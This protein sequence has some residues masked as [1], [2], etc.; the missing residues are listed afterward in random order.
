MFLF[1]H[2]GIGSKLV[3]PW[4][5]KLSKGAV[6]FGTLLPDFIDKPLYYGLSWATGKHGAELGLISGTRTFGHTLIFLFLLST[7]AR[8][9]RSKVVLAIS[10]GILSHLF[11]DSFGEFFQPHPLHAIFTHTPLL[12]PLTGWAFPI[13]PFSNL[14]EHLATSTHPYIFY[15]EVIG[16]WLLI[17]DY[18]KSRYQRRP[19]FIVRALPASD[20]TKRP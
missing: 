11:L 12:W 10:L 3:S 19:H 6:L 14:G 2:L 15:S 13:I 4:T 16:L 17:R 7:G 9:S 1:G 5:R 8:I 20:Q 18:F